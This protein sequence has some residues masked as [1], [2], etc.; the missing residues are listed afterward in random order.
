MAAI[1]RRAGVLRR[2]VSSAHRRL[3]R[4]FD[5]VRA[6]FERDRP[7]AARPPL[8]GRLREALETHLAQEDGLYYPTIWA[9]RPEC[10]EPLE[11]FIRAHEQFRRRLARI[12]DQ[13]ARGKL[14]AARRALDD[15]GRVF[16][17]HERAEERFLHE[18]EAELAAAAQSP[19]SR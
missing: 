6:A 4:M 5:G 11:A 12:G 10:R 16:A 9:L 19:P 3:D 2:R 17:R 13:L 15:F 7:A 18:L 8:F 14:A 1:K